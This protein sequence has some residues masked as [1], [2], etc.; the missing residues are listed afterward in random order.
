MSA[1][2]LD[3]MRPGAAEDYYYYSGDTCKKAAIKTTQNTKYIQQFPN[4]SGGSSTFLFPAQNGL[5]HI[6]ITAQFAALGSQPNLALP[7]AWLYGLIKSVSF[8]YAG[9][10][11]FSITGQQ[12]FLNAAKSQTSRA[13]VNDLV[14]IGGNY[15]AGDDFLN[16]QTASIVLTLPHAHVAS[17][18]GQALPFPTDALTQACQ[19]IVELYPVNSIFSNPTLAALPSG[20]FNLTNASFQV[21]QVMLDNQGDALARRV[22]LST[23]AYAFPTEFVQQEVTVPLRNDTNPQSI[24]TSG[25]RAGQLTSITMWL[26]NDADMTPNGTASKGFN[27]L[28]IYTP[29]SLEMV[30]AGDIYARYDNGVGQ[31]FNLLNSNKASAF[32]LAFV[33]VNVGGISKPT[34]FLAQ[35]LDLPFSQT[36]CDEDAHFILFGGK[37]ITN[38]IININNLVVPYVSSVGWTAHF[39][40]NY[41]CSIL[42]S[43]GSCDYCF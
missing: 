23:S 9:T 42:F 13:S 25:Y 35:W 43:Q 39:S 41:N 34:A 18:V 4:T 10:S 40:Y 6:V 21:Q 27:P 38:G 14:N 26:T 33:N 12:L 7:S 2:A 8:R 15:A 20:C 5:Q 31:L 24:V 3:M 28:A 19:F 11:Q 37:N 16:P 22:D 17:G 30:Y 32:D 36:L 1:S 29:V